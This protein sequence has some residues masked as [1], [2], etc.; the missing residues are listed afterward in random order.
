MKSFKE[1][2][3]DNNPINDNQ[4]PS[5]A[6]DRIHREYFDGVKS[7]DRQ[8]TITKYQ[9]W[10]KNHEK[11]HGDIGLY[12]PSGHKKTPDYVPPSWSKAM[13]LPRR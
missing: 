2:T 8:V 13:G 1:Y 6:A 11:R 10:R 3:N 4:Q 9:E 7:G 5:K 12:L